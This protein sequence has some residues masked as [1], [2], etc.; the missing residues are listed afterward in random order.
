[1]ATLPDDREHLRELN[2][3]LGDA[4]RD[5]HDLLERARELLRRTGQDNDL[6]KMKPNHAD[7]RGPSTP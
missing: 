5:C 3:E 4:L 7:R 1:M 2:R 6:A